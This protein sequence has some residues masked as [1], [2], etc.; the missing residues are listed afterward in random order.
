MSVNLQWVGLACFRLWEDGGPVIVMDPYSP[1]VVAAAVGVDQA[2]F[3]VRLQ[4]DTVIVSSFTDKAHGH[5]Q[6]VDGNPK[7]INALYVALGTSDAR[8]NGEPLVTVQAAEAPHHPEGPDD[9]AMYAFKAGD[10]WI[11][12]MGDLGYGVGAEELAPFAGRC[13]V[14]LA[15]TGEDLTLRLDELEPMIDIL[16]PTWIVPMHYRLPPLS[17]SMTA[18]DAFL[19]LRSRDPIFFAHHHTVRFPVPTQGLGRPTIVV[20]EPSGYEPA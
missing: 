10:L 3:D 19:Q 16:D 14:L 20:L 15:L 7:V 11:L 1:S 5:H 2:V 9:N 6:L 18:V 13:D 12:H 8:I 4:A 17:A